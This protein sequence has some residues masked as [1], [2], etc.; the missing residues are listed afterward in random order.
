MI[1]SIRKE[2]ATKG[3]KELEEFRDGG[4]TLNDLAVCETV[5]EFFPRPE[6]P[7]LFVAIPF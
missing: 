7:P 3:T 4:K 2:I 1:S 6:I 5:L